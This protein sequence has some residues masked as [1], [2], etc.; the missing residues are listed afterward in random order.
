MDVGGLFP[1]WWGLHAT[2][3]ADAMG[4][5]SARAVMVAE[6]AA[7]PSLLARLTERGVRFFTRARPGR[8]ERWI[9]LPVA[10]DPWWSNR[11]GPPGES[12]ARAMAAFDETED[13]AGTLCAEFEQARVALP[14]DREAALERSVS[15]AVTVALGTIAWRLWHR[16]E[17]TDPLLALSRLEDLDARVRFGPRSV[18]IVVPLGRRHRDL[19]EAGLLADVRGVPWLEGR[20][21]EFS[22]G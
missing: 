10:P 14:L 12:V 1:A 11:P 22:G 16:R 13:R 4:A 9:R 3:V 19:H 17:P 2:G 6:S 7:D 8:G 21:L 15:L 18:R 5:T 20:T